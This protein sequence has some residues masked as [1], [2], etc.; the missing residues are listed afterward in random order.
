M[1]FVSP[2]RTSF[3][4]KSLHTWNL[5][6]LARSLSNKMAA[7][8]HSFPLPQEF[9]SSSEFW[10]AEGRLLLYHRSHVW[11]EHFILVRFFLAYCGVVNTDQG[12]S[13]SFC[14]AFACGCYC[15]KFCLTVIFLPFIVVSYL[16]VQAFWGFLQLNFTFR[17]SIIWEWV[18][19]GGCRGM[20]VGKQGNCN[21]YSFPVLTIFLS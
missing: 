6:T 10:L 19:K 13:L 15:T 9:L 4:H 2:L 11:S 7:I 16:L 8:L 14:I 3:S 1:R 18:T 17:I 12:C 5:V 21:L 20:E